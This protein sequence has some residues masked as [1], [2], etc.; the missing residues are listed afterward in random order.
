M[1]LEFLGHDKAAA[2]LD[3]ALTKALTSGEIKSIST[4]SGMKTA[5]YT[6]VVLKYLK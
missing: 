5:E 3:T 4:S 2:R 6:D 1:M